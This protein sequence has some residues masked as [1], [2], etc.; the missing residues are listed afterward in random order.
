MIA[1]ALLWITRAQAQDS[2][3]FTINAA[4]GYS[5]VSGQLYDFNFGEMTVVNT[6]STGSYLLTQGF[7]Q[8]YLITVNLNTATDVFVENNMMTPNG[9]GKNDAFVIQGIDKYPGNK[10][11]IYDRAGR[12][13]FSATN[14][15]N[16]WNAIYNGKPL[17]EDTY[18]Y[19]LELGKNMALIRGFIS[20]ISDKR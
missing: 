3:P 13:L 16:N 19:I 1:L 17:N 10:L 2:L 18:F 7:L 20:I 5:G 8:P 14:Y 11:S 6:F 12:M 15:Q 4:G 9:D